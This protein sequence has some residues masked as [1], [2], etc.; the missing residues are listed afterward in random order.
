MKLAIMQPYFFPYIG[1]WQ[2]IHS[3]NKFVIYDDV[4]FIKQGWI[5]RNFILNNGEKHLVTLQLIGASSFRKINEVLRGKNTTKLLKKID[6]SYR[7]APY[8]K[9]V[10]PLIESILHN[11]E[12]NLSTFLEFSIKEICSF[13]NIATNIML[14]SSLEKDDGLKGQDK[15]LDICTSLKASQYINAIGGQEL[16][17]KDFFL[18]KNID[19]LFLKSKDISYNQFKNEFVSNLS[20]IDVMMFNGKD[21]TQRYLKEYELI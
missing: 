20:I 10:I 15:I 1:Y 14:S 9:E 13:L 19:L 8:H 16:Y 5:N 21:G 11:N 6:Q 4:S 7:K 2:L 17:S 18:N 12:K 3:A